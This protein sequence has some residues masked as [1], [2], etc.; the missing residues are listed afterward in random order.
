VNIPKRVK[1]GGHLL[2]IEFTNDC[3][4]IDYNEIGKTCLGKNIIKINKNYPK[5]RQ[6]ECLLHEII[7]NCL[8]D[9]DE[10]QDESMV[11]RLGT[12]LYSIIKDNPK[13]FK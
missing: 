8:F 9:L 2:D 6:E 3:S 12:M 13:M 7:H 11:T 10:E 4:K 1:I 5:S